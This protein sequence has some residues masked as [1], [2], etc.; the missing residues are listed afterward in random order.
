MCSQFPIQNRYTITAELF[1]ISEHPLPRKLY[2][3]SNTEKKLVAE[4]LSRDLQITM[5]YSFDFPSE[6]IELKRLFYIYNHYQITA[7][8]NRSKMT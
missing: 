3:Y 8:L 1:K 7:K 5:Q 2:F 6:L 4:L